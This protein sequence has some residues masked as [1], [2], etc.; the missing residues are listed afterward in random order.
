[1]PEVS[2]IIPAYNAAVFLPSAIRSVLDQTFKDLEIILIDDGSTDN[3]REVAAS[4]ESSIQYLYISNSGPSA[5][6]NMG[7][8]KSS[9]R[10][11]A[12]LDADDW[13]LPNKL[14]IQIGILSRNPD[15]SFVCADWFNGERGDEPRMSVLSGY[16]AWTQPADFDMMLEENFV[17]SS[18]VVVRREKL[19]QTGPF[20]ERLR[21]AEDRHLWLRL[22]LM[23]NAHV[24]KEILAFRRFHPGNTTSTLP[25]VESQVKMMEDVLTWPIVRSSPLK[26]EVAVKRRDDLLAIM[27]YKL[28]TLGRYKK[29]SHV[30]GQLYAKSYH[31][32]QSGIRYLWFGLLGV[33]ANNDTETNR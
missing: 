26:S 33:F 3:T 8:A 5:A 18:T 4:F 17:N 11:I 6:R 19:L 9:G 12:F 28:S 15:V 25:F 2:V 14:E 30:Y 27:A 23:G 24:C 31:R 7:I 22:L 21:G 16:K 20:L 10:F 32:F 1:M 29:S 13:W